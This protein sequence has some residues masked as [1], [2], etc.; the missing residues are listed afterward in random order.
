VADAHA[1]QAALQ[2][3]ALDCHALASL[4]AFDLQ[5][6]HITASGG[7]LSMRRRF[8]QNVSPLSLGLRAV[9]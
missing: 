6:R 7:R 9:A 2:A 1:F 8:W 4:P 3:V 5:Q